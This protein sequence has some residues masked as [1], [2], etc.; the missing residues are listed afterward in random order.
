MGDAM[1]SRT[2]RKRVARLWTCLAMLQTL[3]LAPEAGAQSAH[4]VLITADEAKLPA[5]PPPRGSLSRASI[6]RGPG[7]ALV[8]PDPSNKPLRSP[9]HL[10]LKIEKRGGVQVDLD[11]LHLAYLKNPEID[12]TGRIKA[13]VKP[14]GVDVPEAEVP[15]GVHVIRAEIKDK[16]GRVASFTFSLN[17]SSE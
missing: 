4:V 7:L 9:I 6:S 14:T 8:S 17:I 12:L 16:D 15:S 10:H 2:A 13:F 3:V 5:Q 1:P 11:S